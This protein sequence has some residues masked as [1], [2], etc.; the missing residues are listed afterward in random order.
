MNLLFN[1]ETRVQPP[2]GE[3]DYNIRTCEHGDY[4]ALF[5]DSPAARVRSTLCRGRE[6]YVELK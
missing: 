4:L 2:K 3:P 5:P 1:T 6:S